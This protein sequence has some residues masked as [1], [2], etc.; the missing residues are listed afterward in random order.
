MT[1]K[2]LLDTNILSEPKRRST[3]RSPLSARSPSH[4]STTGGKLMRD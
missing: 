1:L 4:H 3:E 2:Y